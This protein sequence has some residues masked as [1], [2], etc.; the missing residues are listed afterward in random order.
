[1]E[2][3]RCKINYFVW[4]FFGC[5]IWGSHSGCWDI[6]RCS[7]VKINRHFG[8]INRLHLQGRIATQA[9]YLMLVSW[10]AYSPTLQMEALFFSETSADFHRNTRCYIPE[11]R[12]SY[13]PDVRLEWMQKSTQKSCGSARP[14]IRPPD[15]QLLLYNLCPNPGTYVHNFK[16]I[17]QGRDL[18]KTGEDDTIIHTTRLKI[19]LI[20]WPLND[21]QP[22]KCDV[23]D[24]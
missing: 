18:T 8:G 2:E 3:W 4:L 23:H 20:M 19:Q 17:F 9:A 24:C 21:V 15:S 16:T 11:D 22:Q 14:K 7:P 13:Y 5:R 12:T 10:L 1:M 6:T